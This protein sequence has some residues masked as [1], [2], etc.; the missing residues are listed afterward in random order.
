MC[1]MQGSSAGCDLPDYKSKID[2]SEPGWVR[3]G[4]DLE[5]LG[6]GHDS[7]QGRGLVGGLGAQSQVAQRPGRVVLHC[8]LPCTTTTTLASLLLHMPSC[9]LD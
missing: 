9:C 8:L 3:G 6:E 7:R 4:G 1:A 5:G 2:A